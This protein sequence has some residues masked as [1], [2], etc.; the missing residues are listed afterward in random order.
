MWYETMIIP[1]SDSTYC[2]TYCRIDHQPLIGKRARAPRETG[3][4][5]KAVEI[6]PSLYLFLLNERKSL[7]LV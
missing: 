4:G 6:E 2:D 1:L 3:P 5:E 7:T